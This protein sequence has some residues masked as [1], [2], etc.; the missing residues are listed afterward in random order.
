MLVSIQEIG[1]AFAPAVTGLFPLR[2]PPGMFGVNHVLGQAIIEVN[3]EPGFAGG[4]LDQ[5]GIV[6]SKS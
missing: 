3:K 6:L 5:R 4:C 1:T 2:I